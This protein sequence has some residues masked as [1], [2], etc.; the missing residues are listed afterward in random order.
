MSEETQPGENDEDRPEVEE[1]VT[2][3]GDGV[4]V[5]SGFV[6]EEQEPG[7]LGINIFGPIFEF[8]DD[9]DGDLEDQEDDQESHD[10]TE[11]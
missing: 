8:D 3:F 9:D 5:R 10:E 1:V 2:E 6:I 4:S 11:E 7:V